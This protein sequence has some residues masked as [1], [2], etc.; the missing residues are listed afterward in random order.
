MVLQQHAIQPRNL[1][2]TQFGM[3]LKFEP[4][5]R[6]LSVPEDPETGYN[7][8]KLRVTAL[9]SGDE[10][11]SRFIVFS[12][13]KTHR[14][15][16][17]ATYMLDPQGQTRPLSAFVSPENYNTLAAL[18]KSEN[19]PFKRAHTNVKTGFFKSYW[20]R[21]KHACLAQSPVNDWLKKNRKIK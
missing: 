2:A 11:Y 9:N 13:P 20:P 12:D 18:I 16:Y 10:P 19:S 5:G 1:R 21:L 8:P 14:P 6:V 3:A 4:N 17:T 15:L 7:T